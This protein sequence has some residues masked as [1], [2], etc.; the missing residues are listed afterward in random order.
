MIYAIVAVIFFLIA[1]YTD[2]KRRE[3]PEALTIGLIGAGLFLHLLESLIK[4]DASFI[5]S[6]VYM[7]VLAFVFSYFLYRI[8]AWAGG[9]VKLFTG[10]GAILPYYGQ[11]DYFPFLVFASAFIAAL[12][13]IAIYIGYFFF[14]I[15]KLREMIKP[16]FYRDFKRAIFS[17]S[18][19]V[20]SYEIAA[21]SGLH[22][23]F[24]IPLVYILYKIKWLSLPFIVIPMIFFYLSDT[25]AFLTYFASLAALS[26]L[27]FFGINSFKIAK[28]NILRMTVKVKELEEGMI[29]AED[30][31]IGKVRIANSRSA[32][33][34]TIAE[35]KKLKKARKEIRIRL[36]IPFVPIITLGMLLLMLLEKVIK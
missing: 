12:P 30:V 9:D 24:T 31:Y 14:R 33:G 6:S 10:L 3:V 13:F 35:I 16:I 21:L 18:Y 5:I 7:A 26:F 29:P 19:V 27:L 2:L 1:S 25:M 11:L 34:L 32:D 4:S 17:A 28:E 20:A 36:S 15:R 23:A 22:W 8:G